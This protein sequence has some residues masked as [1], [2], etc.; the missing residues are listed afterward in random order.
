MFRLLLPAAL[1]MMALLGPPAAAETPRI[2]GLSSC[3]PLTGGFPAFVNNPF[4]KD[5][6]VR[7]L[8]CAGQDGLR[9]D[10]QVRGW[11]A[12]QVMGVLA[13]GTPFAGT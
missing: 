4:S 8:A 5:D 11:G 2:P 9:F 12:G 10:G 6:C 3:A 1:S 7:V 13:D